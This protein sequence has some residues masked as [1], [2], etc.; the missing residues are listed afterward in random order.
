MFN[1]FSY[2]G[3]WDGSN[4]RDALVGGAVGAALATLIVVMLLVLVALYIYF[5]LA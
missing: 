1:Y 4:Y 3:N 5:A 2:F